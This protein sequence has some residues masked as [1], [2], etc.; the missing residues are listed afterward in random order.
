MKKLMLSL[1]AA[2]TVAV[3]AHVAPVSGASVTSES[4]YAV[5]NEVGYQGTVWNITDGTGAW[6]TNGPRDANLYFVNDAPQIWTNYNQLL[7]SWFEH[8]PS[9]QNDS[10]IQLS[11]DGNSSV[12]SQIASWDSTGTVFTMTVTG[13][14]APY[15]W[16][17]FWQPD[18]NMAWGV[19]FLDYTYT[20]AATFDSAAQVD[21]NNFMVSSGNM[22]S[23]VGS[24]TGTFQSTYDVNKKPITNGD[25]YGFNIGLD[26]A[27]FDPNISDLYG[28]GGGTR[29][30][31]FGV[32]VPLPAALYPGLALLGALGGLKG[33]KRLR[34]ARA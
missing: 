23:I 10:F 31:E 15:P 28:Y 4:F 24:F 27:L 11:E 22:L 18:Q 2:V 13:A 1:T 29:C 3:A 16:S 19:T 5:T 32:A 25:I 14:N 30:S 12:T 17:R 33:F 34:T 21:A 6:Q 8:A 9:N 7:S 20:F 26:S